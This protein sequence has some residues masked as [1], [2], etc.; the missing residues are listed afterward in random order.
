[1]SAT[2]NATFAVVSG[3]NINQLTAKT[4]YHDR[5]VGFDFTAKQPQ[6]SLSADGSLAL[7]PDQNKVSLHR[8]AFQTENMAWQTA[9]GATAEIVYGG[10][11]VA[12]KDLRLVSN[13]QEIAASGTFGRARRHPAGHCAEREP[14][15][16]RRAAAA[17]ADAVGHARTPPPKSPARSDAPKVAGKFDVVQG[18]FRQARFD[19]LG[20]TVNYEG[21]GLTLDTRLHQSAS[22]WLEA[23]GYVPV[24]AFKKAATPGAHEE[25]PAAKE[26][27]FDLHIHSTPIELALVQ[28]TD[29]RAY[30]CPGHDAG[31]D[32]H[33]GRRRRSASERCDH[34]DNA[35]FTVKPT[36]V[37]YTDLD[38]RIELEADRIHIADIE[39]LDNDQQ[40][41]SITGDLAIHERQLGGVNIDVTARNFKI[42]KNKMGDIRMDSDFRI[43]GDLLRPRI[44]GELGVTSGVINLDPVLASA[45]GPPAPAA[46]TPYRTRGFRDT[47]ARRS[48][49]SRPPQHARR[50]DRNPA[51]DA[52]QPRRRRRPRSANQNAAPSGGSPR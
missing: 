43:T 35:A 27:A 12:V 15:N 50:A 17:P 9:P 10:G 48:R 32:R 21:R 49:R 16:H 8:L 22:S 18:A 1:M 36:G 41:L 7:N 44:E 51:A 31:D 5:N 25:A 52:A 4:E 34:V 6:R 38:G 24:A 29:D 42:I 14:G 19:S 26:D 30:Q 2:T 47:H 40:P 20:G 33:H 37:T 46:P 11:S 45:G 23:K 39:V 28:G 13:N 3:Q